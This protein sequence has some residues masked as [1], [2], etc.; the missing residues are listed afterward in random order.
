M[1]VAEEDGR[2]LL[3]TLEHGV[4]HMHRGVGVEIRRRLVEDHDVVTGQ[5][6][7]GQ[8]EALRLAAAHPRPASAELAV[9]SGGQGGEPL[10][11]SHRMQCL[12]EFVVA[13]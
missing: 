5:E 8:S 11:E 10:V 7:S 6:H 13:R 4:E 9:Q 1:G 12:A 2:A 3:A